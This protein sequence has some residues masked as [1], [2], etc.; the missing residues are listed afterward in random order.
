MNEIQIFE[1]LEFG[2]VR[3]IVKD[4]EPW[5][6][7]KDICDVFGATNRNRIMQ[8]LD[9]DEK[10]YTQVTTPGGLQETATVNESGLYRLLFSLQPAKARGVSDEYVQERIG[11]LKAFKRWVTHEVIPAI[12]KTGMYMTENA[13]QNILNNPTAFIEILTEYKKVQ[14][15]N[16]SLT[17]QNAS[18]KQLIGELKPKA[19]Y[20]DLILKSKSLVTI[21]QIAKDYGMSGQAMNKIL[22]NLGII[23]NQSG[24]WLLYSK[25]QAKGYTHS[26][27][28]NIVHSD[29]REDVKMNTKWT[30][31]GRLFL[32]NTLKK[33][34]II[35]VIEKGA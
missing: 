24:Q 32:Y 1:N 9:E 12:R 22:H 29:G 13:V 35:P 21:T 8:D 14:D 31:K 27:T 7:A 17:M 18:Q 19:D 2:K 6:V 30:Q 26:E 4:G 33:E 23:Y 28:V 20:T 5:F 11:K 16:K 34:N 3:S 15:E 25:H 10:G